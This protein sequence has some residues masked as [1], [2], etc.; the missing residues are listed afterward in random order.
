[1][2]TAKQSPTN[3][4]CSWCDLVGAPKIILFFFYPFFKPLKIPFKF[5]CTYTLN[6]KE[7]G[8]KILG[9]NGDSNPD[10]CDA[11]AVLHQLSY[12]AN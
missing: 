11:G 6:S 3:L 12:Y 4:V 1:M 10:L 7:K 9:L 8:L 5:T 2:W